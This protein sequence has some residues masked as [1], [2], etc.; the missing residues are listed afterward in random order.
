MKKFGLILAIAAIAGAAQAK[1][2]N[3]D[4]LLEGKNTGMGGANSRSIS[5]MTVNVSN[6]PSW[7]LYG[8]AQNIVQGYNIGANSHVV[9]IGWDVTLEADGFSW[10]DDMKVSFEDSTQ[11]LGVWL[12]PGVGDTFA[13]VSTYSSGGVIDLIQY[14]LDFNVGGDGTLRMEYFEGYDDYSNAI[15]GYWLGG[16]LTIAYEQVPAPSAMAL[17]GGAGLLVARRRR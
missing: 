13:G 16:T 7:D 12:T 15:D 9:G 11:A 4:R 6:L 17:L 5:Y 8:D 10:L 2:G 14:A 1:N 3:V